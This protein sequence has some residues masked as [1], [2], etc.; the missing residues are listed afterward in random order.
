MTAG[1]CV[2]NDDDLR[3]KL[4]VRCGEWD[5]QNEDESLPYQERRVNRVMV[6]LYA[7][8]D[9]CIINICPLYSKKHPDLDTGNHHNNFALLFMSTA[10]KLEQH[11]SPICL[12]EPRT[13][14]YN[15]QLCVAHG[16][17]KDKFG[18]PGEY[19]TVLKEVVTPTVA[20]GICERNLR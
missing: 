16:W 17:G 5:T 19:Q 1:H 14:P 7:A 20:N 18:S 6:R 13:K 15:T 2:D 9:V 8:P 10:F 12:P 11:I 3:D 4:S